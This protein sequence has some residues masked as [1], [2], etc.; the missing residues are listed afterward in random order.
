M[1]I[2]DLLG[3]LGGD[4]V[5][6]VLQVVRQVDD[7]W[8]GLM[9]AVDFIAEHGEGLI[10]L[11]GRL[12][13]IL[14]R[15]GEA[16]GTAAE[17]AIEAS[18]FLTA[19]DGL[20]ADDIAGS[21]GMAMAVC[22]E[23]L[24]A[25][26]GLLDRVGNELAG[27]NVPAFD[28]ERSEVM[29]LSVVSGIDVTSN[30]VA[31]GAA[32]DVKAGA[33]QLSEVAEA[34]AAAGDG[35]GRLQSNLGA[36]GTRINSLA[37]D[38]EA[39]GLALTEL[40]GGGAKKRTSR[41]RKAKAQKPSSSKTK[42]RSAPQRTTAKAKRTKTAKKASTKKKSTNKK[43]VAAKSSS[44]KRST[45]KKQTPSKSTR[46]G[47]K[48]KSTRT[49]KNTRAAKNTRSKRRP[50]TKKGQKVKLGQGVLRPRS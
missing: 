46:T 34:L 9:Q 15:A 17:A 2:E 12:P 21:A 41:T 29:G 28:I 45:P 40:S 16:L 20:D 6:R 5:Q 4:Q 35:L 43:K 37:A 3:S 44:K 32:R 38:V 26:A 1:D 13:D 49:T 18:S 42:K 50:A 11:L 14:D 7:N 48:A 33:R 19:G 36:A 24:S 25:V 22:Q 10:D 27:I 8:D 47:K 30:R 23:H 31:A 39:S